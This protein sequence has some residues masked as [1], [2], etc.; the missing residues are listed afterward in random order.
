MDRETIK[1]LIDEYDVDTLYYI[2][3]CKEHWVSKERLA[4]LMY[5]TYKI[6]QMTFDEAKD[7]VDYLIPY[8]I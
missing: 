8:N 6:V 3:L 4:E 1:Y 7:I 5:D 2:D